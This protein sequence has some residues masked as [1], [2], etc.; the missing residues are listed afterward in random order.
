MQDWDRMLGMLRE[1]QDPR[2]LGKG[3]VF[4]TYKYVGGRAKGYDTWLKAQE[5]RLSEAL[6]GPK[7]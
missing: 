6:K 7:K 1:E 5:A 3:E 4:D 2:A